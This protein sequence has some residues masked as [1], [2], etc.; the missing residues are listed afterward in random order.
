MIL[1][2]GRTRRVLW[3]R[4]LRLRFLVLRCEEAEPTTCLTTARCPAT[5]LSGLLLAGPDTSTWKAWPAR[6]PE[7]AENTQIAQSGYGVN[8]PPRVLESCLLYGF[9][10]SHRVLDS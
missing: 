8:K 9:P 6:P 1:T 10:A 2:T 3:C 4:P 5:R 7:S